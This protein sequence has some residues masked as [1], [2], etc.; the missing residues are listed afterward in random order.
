MKRRNFAIALV[1]A[2]ILQSSL[3][4]Y[5]SLGWFRPDLPLIVLTFLAV[6]RG[7]LEGAVAGFLVGL[8]SDTLSTSFFG[9]ASLAYSTAA[10][11]SG[12]LF[13]SDTPLSLDR[14]ALVSAISAISYTTLFSYFYTL[15]D[16]VPFGTMFVRQALP[17]TAYT[18]IIGMIWAISPLY[19][20][21]KGIR[22]N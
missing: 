2:I 1:G 13:Y 7:P 12:K 9:L 3:V 20:R 14:W 19:E 21:R 6:R 10:F 22:L 8:V 16:P 17:T 5:L 18:W 11:L 4:P 15:G